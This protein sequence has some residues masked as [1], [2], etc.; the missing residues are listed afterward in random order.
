[1]GDGPIFLKNLHTSLNDDLSID[2]AFSLL[3]S[4]FKLLCEIM[5]ANIRVI[6]AH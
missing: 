4:T 6:E 3:D 1:M 5:E 2:T